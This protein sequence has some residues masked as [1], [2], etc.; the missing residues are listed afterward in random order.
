M[1]ESLCSWIGGVDVGKTRSSYYDRERLVVTLGFLITPCNLARAGENPAGR[2]VRRALA[3][4]DVPSLRAAHHA[5]AD[6]VVL[7]CWVH[8]Y[9]LLYG[10]GTFQECRSSR[11]VAEGRSVGMLDSTHSLP[12]CQ[13]ATRWR[14]AEGDGG[15]H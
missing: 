10:L 7:I 2:V 15:R 8:V 1:V 9:L 5:L 13:G 4:V 6:A 14:Q 12:T 3:D 11:R